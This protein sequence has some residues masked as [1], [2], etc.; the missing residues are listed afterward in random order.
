M[1]GGVAA[2]LLMSACARPSAQGAPE[3]G[4]PTDST[5]DDIGAMTAPLLST[6]CAITTTSMTIQVADGET[7][8]VSLRK[9]DGKVVLNA[10]TATFGPCEV[11]SSAFTIRL[12]AW[13]TTAVRGRTVILDYA[14]G[15]FLQSSNGIPN[16]IIDMNVATN[17]ANDALKVRGTS[18]DDAFTF[19]LSG[20]SGT[21]A[22]NI[23]AGSTGSL[24]SYADVTIRQ[25]EKVIVTGGSGNDTISGDGG[26][27]TSGPYTGSLK[28]F[29]GPGDD[30]LTGGS[31]NDTLTGGLGNDTMDGML[32]D[33]VIKM[34][35]GTDGTD[36]VN[37]SG[38]PTGNDTVDYSARTADLVLNLDDTATSG[39]LGENDTLSSSIVTLI[40]G[41]GDDA[42]TIGNGTTVNHNV[43]G[44]PGDDAF[45]G[46]AISYDVFD[47]Q[48]G[49]DVCDGDTGT[50]TYA[51][52]SNPV[53]V[54]LC[55]SRGDCSTSQDDGDQT[56]A[57][58][59][60]GTGAAAADDGNT[61]NHLV[62]IS[63]LTG[64]TVADV[65]RKIELTGFQT[66]LNDDGTTGYTI[67]A[68]TATTV[69]INVASNG[70]FNESSLMAMSMPAGLTWTVV[71]PEKD[72]VECG[73]VIGSPQADTLTGDARNNIIH[74]GAGDD[75]LSGDIGDDY[76]YG[77]DGND[78]MWGGPGDDH[79]IGGNGNDTMVGGDGNDIL[80]GDS[81][82]DSFT[83][84]GVN[85]SGG[86][87]GSM[88][89]DSDA[90]ID[91]IMGETRNADCN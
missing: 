33:D 74:G 28:L 8:V 68:Q 19:G 30:A 4:A 44:G 50:M 27:G 84:D 62:T 82:T 23:N 12:T 46:G 72:N 2:L 87:T 85:Q 55:D 45:G 34:N 75:T 41:A 7:A 71:G 10:L 57:T 53:T 36:V 16:V 47:G 17:G 24:D 61:S 15:L 56:V 39:A 40:A 79:L 83:C 80:E 38:S 77:E 6:S 9:T 26:F 3:E 20:V 65:G 64:I 14:G 86:A 81:G 90:T 1:L 49:D 78:G 43:F 76:L 88:P 73:S 5:D 58:R 32:G 63:S 60:S 31:G 29:G 35:A 51:S 25:V 48:A 18:G 22:F 21:S 11:P 54:T 13:G 59:K 91:A 69:T 42:I 52:R 37:C 67:T 70:S 89:G 66:A